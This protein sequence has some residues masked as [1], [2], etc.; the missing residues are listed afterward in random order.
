M[1]RRTLI[2][3]ALGAIA[4]RPGRATAQAA[5]GDAHLERMRALADAVLPQTIGDEGRARALTQFMAWVRD[6][7]AGADGDHGYGETACGACRRRRR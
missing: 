7:R 4:L 1:K 2:K 6:Y 3:S 5:F